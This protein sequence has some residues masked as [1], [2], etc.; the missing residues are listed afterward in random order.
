QKEHKETQVKIAVSST[1]KRASSVSVVPV[2]TLPVT[3]KTATTVE[4][5]KK[6]ETIAKAVPPPIKVEKT[7][8]EV[9]KQNIFDKFSKKV[10]K[11]TTALYNASAVDSLVKSANSIKMI[12]DADDLKPM[13]YLFI[14]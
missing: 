12:D 9:K 7:V 14:K 1:M 11:N 13:Y 2:N 4:V 6:E 10:G 8:S 3:Q 5:I